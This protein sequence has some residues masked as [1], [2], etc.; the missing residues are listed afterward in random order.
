ME[1]NSKNNETENSKVHAVNDNNDF[2]K[3]AQDFL[4]SQLPADFDKKL[5]EYVSAKGYNQNEFRLFAHM[6]EEAVGFH[7]VVFLLKHYN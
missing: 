4:T 6:L 5:K 3:D 7:G 1:E 2:Y